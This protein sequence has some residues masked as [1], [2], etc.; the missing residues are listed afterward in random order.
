M[1]DAMSEFWWGDTAD[2]KRMHWMACFCKEM[3]EVIVLWKLQV[4]SKVKFFCMEGSAWN[5]TGIGSS[6]K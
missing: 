6:S 4:P 2:I 5:S 1:T 3:T